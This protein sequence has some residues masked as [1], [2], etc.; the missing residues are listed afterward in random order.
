MLLPRIQPPLV[1]C[2]YMPRRQYSHFPQEEMHEISTAS[3]WAKPVTL[4]PASTMTPVPSWPRMRP[5]WQ[6]A[7]SP[8]RICRS[9]PQ[10]VVR[11]ILTMASVGCWI[12]GMGRF[13][14]RIFP[15][16]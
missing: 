12:S 15:G 11:V 9:V 13:S 2:E 14:S 8:L 3:P 10:M 7:T 6:V 4:E 1:Q 5:G 16:P